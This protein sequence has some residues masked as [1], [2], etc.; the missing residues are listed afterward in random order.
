MPAHDPGL[1]DGTLGRQILRQ[2]LAPRC[3]ELECDVVRVSKGQCRVPERVHD[4]TVGDAEFVEMAFPCSQLIAA[5]TA[6]SQMIE[7]RPA[8]VERLSAAQIREL[9]A[10]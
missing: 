9:G 4:A 1:G 5:G 10:C 2:V 8:L 7:P 3:E 6:E